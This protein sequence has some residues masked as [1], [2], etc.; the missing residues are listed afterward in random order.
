M[1]KKGSLC[2][3][4]MKRNEKVRLLGIIEGVSGWAFAVF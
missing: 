4:E 1:W 2:Y 3:D